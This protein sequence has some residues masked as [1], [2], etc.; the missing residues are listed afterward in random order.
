MQC[1]AV[2]LLEVARQSQ[3]TKDDNAEITSDIQK[4]LNLL[5]V[6]QPQ[7]PVAD[8]AYHVVCRILHNVAPVLQSKAAE[9]LTEGVASQAAAEQS[10]RPP[11]APDT[12]Q[13]SRASWTPGHFFDGT[14]SVT[15][16]Q[17]YPQG[18]NQESQDTSQLSYDH[19]MYGD[20]PLPN[21]TISSTFGNPFINNWDEGVPVIDMQNLW[22]NPGFPSTDMPE[23]VGDMNPL[24]A[25][26]VE[27]QHPQ[28]QQQPPGSGGTNMPRGQQQQRRE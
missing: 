19:S 9:L 18:L 26:Y 8:R 20:F 15:D 13:Q 17:Y 21:V 10:F 3:H 12:Q 6:M 24:L 4:L 28:H 7:D 22:Y 11:I 5:H 14:S 27:Q 23:H 1:A 16:H 25:P 2:L